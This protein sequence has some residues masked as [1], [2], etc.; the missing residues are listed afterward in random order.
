MTQ[1]KR[2]KQGA[3]NFLKLTDF[4]RQRKLRNNPIETEKIEP[5][6]NHRLGDNRQMGGKEKGRASVERLNCTSACKH[7]SCLLPLNSFFQ[8]FST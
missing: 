2:R 3:C 6:I 4:T 7:I 8:F 5:V 1:T